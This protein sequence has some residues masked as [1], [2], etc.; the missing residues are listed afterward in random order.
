MTRD[1]FGDPL[2]QSPAALVSAFIAEARRKAV[3]FNAWRHA[4]GVERVPRHVGILVRFACERAGL[5]MDGTET[6]AVPA[7]HGRRCVVWGASK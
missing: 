6:A 5:T 2:P 1:L 4:H 3:S 7:S